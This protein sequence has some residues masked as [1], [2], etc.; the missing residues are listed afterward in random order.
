VAVKACAVEPPSGASSVALSL[1]GRGVCDFVDIDKPAV[2]E[3]E[4]VMRT[5]EF[6]VVTERDED[7]R[8]VAICPSLQ[9]CYTEGETE[10][11]ALELIRDAVRLHVEARIGRGEPVYEEVSISTVRVEV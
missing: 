7:G 6:T 8:Y 3:Y 5:Y 1:S 2:F 4:R 9:G 11:E 10:A